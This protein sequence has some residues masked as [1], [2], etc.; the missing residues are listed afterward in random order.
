MVKR[1]FSEPLIHFALLALLIFA[2]YYALA[3][4]SGEQAPDAIVVT[5]AKIEQMAAIFA[6]T[7]QRP[8]SVEEMKGLVDDY[9]KEEIYVREAIALGLDKDD[10]V[11]RR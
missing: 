6:K 10:T 5:G 1:L 2:G 8:P 11:I 4:R 7:W 9:V 3:P